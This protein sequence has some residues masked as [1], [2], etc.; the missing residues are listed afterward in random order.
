MTGD[1]FQREG[2]ESSL[3]IL[4]FFKLISDTHSSKAPYICVSIT[5][6]YRSEEK[7][8]KSARDEN[9]VWFTLQYELLCGTF[10]SLLVFQT[11]WTMCK[12][13]NT[14]SWAL[15]CFCRS[16]PPHSLGKTVIVWCLWCSLAQKWNK[17]RWSGAVSLTSCLTKCLWFLNLLSR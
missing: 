2:I 17:G 4:L 7:G 3:P 14:Q 13:V 9:V 1:F 16:P 12:F 15:L 6:L 8:N 11:V 10:L 5:F